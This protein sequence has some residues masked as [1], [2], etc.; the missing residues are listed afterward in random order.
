MGCHRRQV[1][2]RYR[3]ASRCGIARRQRF[4]PACADA[5]GNR[6]LSGE[7]LCRS[8]CD[9]ASMVLAA[10]SVLICSTSSEAFGHSHLSGSRSV[11]QSPAWS[12]SRRSVS[13]FISQGVAIGWAD[14]EDEAALVKV[15][16]VSVLFNAY[17]RE[18]H[19]RESAS[20]VSEAVLQHER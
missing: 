17:L 7:C 4:L 1:A 8:R 9:M 10:F 13:P 11:V 6:F 5:G 16:E 20:G 19:D 18:G 15:R 12:W 2:F 3:P 14:G